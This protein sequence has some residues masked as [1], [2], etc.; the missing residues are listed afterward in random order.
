[1]SEIITPEKAHA[2]ELEN[3]LKE[4][5]QTYELSYVDI[6]FALADAI[7]NNAHKILGY[8]SFGDFC[9]TT[10][11][12]G[13]RK[14]YYCAKIAT[15]ADKLGLTR[16]QLAEKKVSKLIEI[17]T[18]NPDTH[19]DKMM[20]LFENSEELTVD[21]IRKEVKQLNKKEGSSPTEYK[22]FKLFTE[23]AAV[24]EQAIELA[25]LNHGSTL[26]DNGDVQRL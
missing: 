22:T 24:L 5:S 1:M 15:T 19:S 2:L 9:E 13:Q 10:L 16:Q 21:D 7:N 8:A 23:D 14:G 26:S 4:L 11:G 25:R 12:F 6:C 17:F 18:L 20:E 3:K